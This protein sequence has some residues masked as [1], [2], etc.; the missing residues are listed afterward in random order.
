MNPLQGSNCLFQLHISDKIWYEKIDLEKWKNPNQDS[1]FSSHNT[2]NNTFYINNNSSNKRM[3]TSGNYLSLANPLQKL[4]MH[5]FFELEGPKGGGYMTGKHKSKFIIFE[6]KQNSANNI[7]HRYF[8][9]ALFTVNVTVIQWY[10]F[11]N[12]SVNEN[13]TFYK[14]QYIVHIFKLKPFRFI[15]VRISQQK[16]CNLL[17]K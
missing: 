7:F 3:A 4:P 17:Q 8:I 11:V 5:E 9:T 15:E 10:A 6:Q 13:I 1:L 14:Y 2:C 12:N 16:H